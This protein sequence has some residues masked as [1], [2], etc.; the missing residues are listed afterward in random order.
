MRELT[1]YE[2]EKWFDR[3][4]FEAPEFLMDGAELGDAYEHVE[5]ATHMGSYG[6]S[7]EYVQAS[8]VECLDMYYGQLGWIYL[9]GQED[10]EELGLPSYDVLCD[11]ANEL[12]VPE[13]HESMNDDDRRLWDWA[14]EWRE[15]HLEETQNRLRAERLRREL[16]VLEGGQ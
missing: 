11:R 16:R 10:P 4:H 14:M 6:L 12:G 13:F 7:I 1:E 2:K 9:D 3:H 8:V 5:R 15:E